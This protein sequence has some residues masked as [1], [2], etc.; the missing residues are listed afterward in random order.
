MQAFSTETMLQEV[1]MG[2][3]VLHAPIMDGVLRG[4]KVAPTDTYTRSCT[5][6]CPSLDGPCANN[7][8]SNWRLLRPIRCRHSWAQQAMSERVQTRRALTEA[9]SYLEH[10]GLIA[11]DIHQSTDHVLSLIHI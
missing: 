1:A 8:F 5:A 3:R 9:W 10:L 2:C 11:P 4:R 6:L 7:I